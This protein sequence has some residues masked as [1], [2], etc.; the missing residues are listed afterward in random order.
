MALTKI[1]VANKKKI[2]MHFQF[3]QTFGQHLSTYLDAGFER[4]IQINDL[5]YVFLHGLVD[6]ET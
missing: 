6:Y 4:I 1:N 5:P 3:K 2:K